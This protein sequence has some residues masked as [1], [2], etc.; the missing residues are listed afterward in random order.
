MVI[1]ELLTAEITVLDSKGVGHTR[2]VLSSSCTQVVIGHPQI[3]GLLGSL[4][5]DMIVEAIAAAEELASIAAHDLRCGVPTP[6]FSFIQAISSVRGH[7]TYDRRFNIHR[8]PF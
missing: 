5:R 2:T 1:E 3:I 8:I 7:T 6:V 4:F